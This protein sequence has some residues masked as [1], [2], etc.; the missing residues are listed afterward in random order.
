[1]PSGV[2]VDQPLGHQGDNQDG[3][4]EEWAHGSRVTEP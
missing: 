4:Q 2:D 3:D 1:M